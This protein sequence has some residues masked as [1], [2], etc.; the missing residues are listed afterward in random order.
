MEN[1]KLHDINIEQYVRYSIQIFE[2]SKGNERFIK[3]YSLFQELAEKTSENSK[4]EMK[5][6]MKNK[7]NKLFDND[8]E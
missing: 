8:K 5:I 2:S 3:L 7:I 4:M 6:E 1:K